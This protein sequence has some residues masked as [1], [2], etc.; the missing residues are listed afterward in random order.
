MQRTALTSELVQYRIKES[1]PK[2]IEDIIQVKRKVLFLFCVSNK[3]LEV[4]I[5]RTIRLT[6]TQTKILPLCSLLLIFSLVLQ[7]VKERNFDK[8]AEI[9]MKDSNQFHAVCLDT[10]P[11]NIYMNDISH[12][13][14]SF[15]HTYNELF[16]KPKVIYEAFLIASASLVKELF[17]SF[18]H[19]F[20]PIDSHNQIINYYHFFPLFIIEI[21]SFFKLARKTLISHFH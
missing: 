20:L 19:L 7:A 16:P 14:T 13:I 9:T 10:Y 3:K 17:I 5:L 15:V 11:P 4:Q 18:I 8:F 2:R 1:V 6:F 21:F 12:E